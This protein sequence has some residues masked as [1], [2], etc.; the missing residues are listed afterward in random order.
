MLIDSVS[1]RGSSSGGG[2]LWWCL[3]RC[4]GVV[5]RCLLHLVRGRVSGDRLSPLSPS[6]WTAASLTHQ[7]ESEGDSEG[8]IASKAE[9]RPQWPSFF[10]AFS[11][12]VGFCCCLFLSAEGCEWGGTLCQDGLI[13]AELKFSSPLRL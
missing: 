6:R 11:V 4:E 7:H 12:S 13:T 3:R 9:V 1:V 5:R 2:G 8:E 10:V